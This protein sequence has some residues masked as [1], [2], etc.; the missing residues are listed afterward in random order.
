MAEFQEIATICAPVEKVFEYRLNVKTLPEYN[1][2]VT[3]LVALQDEPAEGAVYE[4]KV[5]AGGGVSLKTKLTI[6]RIDREAYELVFV[7]DSLMN[8][9]ELVKFTAIEENGEPAT[10]IEFNMKVLTPGGPLAPLLDKLFVIKSARTQVLQELRLMKK[11]L[12]ASSAAR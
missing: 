9:R 1:P 4:F 11:N 3:D 7:M 2:D 5:K 8:A 10:R 12:E 6:E